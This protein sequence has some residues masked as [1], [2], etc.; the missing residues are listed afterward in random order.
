MGKILCSKPFWALLMLS[1]G[2][3]WFW[4]L[5]MTGVPIYMNQ[6]LGFAI[7]ST[8]L[9]AAVPYMASIL[10]IIL[11]GLAGDYLRRRQIMSVIGIR[12]SFLVFCE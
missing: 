7:S 8:G 4:Y 1:F 5:M 10:G 12:K 2:N 3:D 11:F 9:L 6:I